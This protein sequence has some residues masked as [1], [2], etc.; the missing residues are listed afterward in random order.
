M[1]ANDIERIMMLACCTEADAKEAYSK[2]QDVIESV[3][4]ILKI[5]ETRGAP[6]PKIQKEDTY[7]NLRVL[8][9][10]ADRQIEEKFKKSNPSESSSQVSSRNPGPAREE[11]T[12]RSDCTQSSHLLTLEEGA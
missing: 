5:P 8:M 6:K 2:T 9:Q 7:T 3:D 12:L 10:E 1:S 4:A 11:M